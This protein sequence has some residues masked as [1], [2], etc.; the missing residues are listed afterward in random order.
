MELLLTIEVARDL[1]RRLRE[2]ME[3]QDMKTCRDLLEFRYQAMV[4][5]EGAHRAASDQERKIC[6]VKMV[7]LK[8]ADGL[9]LKQSED[10]LARVATEF[11]G[12]LGLPANGQ[13][14]VGGD[15][16]QACLDKK[17]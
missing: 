4:D 9:L 17:A 8:K 11:R 1:T 2:A 13:H 10:I 14:P 7:E 3:G 16:L 6:H 15:P 5:F 12:Q